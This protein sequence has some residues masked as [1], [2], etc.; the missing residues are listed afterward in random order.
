MTLDLPHLEHRHRRFPPPQVD[1]HEAL[2]VRNEVL[3]RRSEDDLRLVDDVA[4]FGDFVGVFDRLAE[5]LRLRPELL[6]DGPSGS[7]NCLKMRKLF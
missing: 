1:P 5:V 6:R 2:L 7:E 3:V 4:D